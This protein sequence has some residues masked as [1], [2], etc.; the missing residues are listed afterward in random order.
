MVNQAPAAGGT[1][2]FTTTQPPQPVP[3]NDQNVQQ[4]PAV[5]NQKHVTFATPVVQTAQP[6]TGLVNAETQTDKAPTLGQRIAA[7]FKSAYNYVVGNKPA[8]TTT[9]GQAT[10]T[11]PAQTTT[12][13]QTTQTTQTAPAATTD[14]STPAADTKKTEKTVI[15]FHKPNWKERFVAAVKVVGSYIAAP[16]KFAAKVIDFLVWKPLKNY[17]ITPIYV[18]FLYIFQPAKYDA[19]KMGLE[20]EADKAA[21]ERKQANDR[22]LEKDCIDLARARM[23]DVSTQLNYSRLATKYGV[24]AEDV[25]KRV[26]AHKAHQ[27]VNKEFKTMLAKGELELLKKDAHVDRETGEKIHTTHIV[28][29][30]NGQILDADKADVAK[31]LGNDPALKQEMEEYNKAVADHEK[32][33]AEHPKAVKKAEKEGKPVPPKPELTAKPPVFKCTDE[34]LI[35]AYRN[36]SSEY[37]ANV[38]AKEAALSNELTNMKAELKKA[39][40]N[41]YAADL[42]FVIRH[43]AHKAQVEDT[44]N[45][46]QKARQE[47][48][49]YLAKWE[50]EGDNHTATP[51]IRADI[52]ELN[53]QIDILER[54]LAIYSK[55]CELQAVHGEIK[56]L[57]KSIPVYQK[58]MNEDVTD[59]QNRDRL[60][61]KDWKAPV[62]KD[63]KGN[64]TS[65]PKKITHLERTFKQMTT[66][67]HNGRKMPNP[68]PYK[69]QKGESWS[70]TNP[71][72]R[73]YDS[74]MAVKG[75]DG[76]I[77]KDREGNVVDWEAAAGQL[78]NHWVVKHSYVNGK[79]AG[80]DKYTLA[81]KKPEATVYYESTLPSQEKT[82][83]E[84]LTAVPGSTVPKS[85]FQVQQES[86]LV[87]E[88]LAQALANPAKNSDAHLSYFGEDFETKEAGVQL[89]LTKEQRVQAYVQQQEKLRA[90]GVGERLAGVRT[91]LSDID[92]ESVAE[93]Y[94]IDPR[95]AGDNPRRPDIT[96]ADEMERCQMMARRMEQLAEFREPAP[97]PVYEPTIMPTNVE[98]RRGGEEIADSL[99]SLDISC[100][101]CSS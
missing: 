87:Q 80:Y 82:D 30:D 23:D 12:G 69:D 79:H 10:Q 16:F 63:E 72:Q 83:S 36:G 44:L 70:K 71:E 25:K 74:Y 32:A 89:R 19:R 27:D 8:Q 67:E 48:Q 95:G 66:P 93:T 62:A 1:P 91:L 78:K 41:A 58:Q 24:D 51:P 96:P 26:V 14:A 5:M 92:E 39:Y 42:E 29:F 33:L 2:T 75:E 7:P 61:T 31:R 49:A 15:E 21:H 43:D 98:H 34:K 54:N 17:V 97:E 60:N 56:D 100:S 47:Q 53:R 50:A 76:K 84:G 90:Q 3:Q 20:A 59:R 35:Q 77:L 52:D 94:T 73:P 55:D 99:D 22:A 65:D 101:H 57:Q 13:G 88:R 9:G 38:K 11:V 85:A 28:R 4:N 86:K 64:V 18:G 81:V 68:V 46:R 45:A 40:P 6:V 37:F